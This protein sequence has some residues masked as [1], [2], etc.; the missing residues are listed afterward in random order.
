MQY[1]AVLCCTEDWVQV[2]WPLPTDAKLSPQ[3]GDTAL[4]GGQETLPA[5]LAAVSSPRFLLTTPGITISL[6][7]RTILYTRKLEQRLKILGFSADSY[8]QHETFGQLASE[9]YFYL[10]LHFRSLI[11]SISDSYAFY[12]SP[13]IF[14]REAADL[15]LRQFC[16]VQRLELQTF[17]RCPNFMFTYHGLTPVKHSVLIV[18]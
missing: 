1:C 7:L 3:G 11:I 6:F 15:S 17:R 4:G 16:D 18:F 2:S 13:S 8:S 5:P 10:H 9:S 14:C 12:W